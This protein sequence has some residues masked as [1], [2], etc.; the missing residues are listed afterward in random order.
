M[1]I[2]EIAEKYG[3][4]YNIAYQGTYRVQAVDGVIRDREYPEE[5]VVENIK[6]ILLERMKRHLEKA[7][8]LSETLATVCEKAE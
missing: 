2:K 4:S 8:E 6:M 3:V 7:R 1:T 5:L